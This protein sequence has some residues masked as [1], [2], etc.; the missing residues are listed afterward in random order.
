MRGGRP[1]SA[2]PASVAS[3]QRFGQVWRS[4]RE[5]AASAAAT[6]GS[7]A[8]AL[9]RSKLLYQNALDA[10][11]DWEGTTRGSCRQCAAR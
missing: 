3:R 11:C 2:Q 6:A 5:G 8:L 1:I 10:D 7:I 4:A 9:R